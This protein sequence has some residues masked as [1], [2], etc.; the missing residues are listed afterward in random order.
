MNGSYAKG[1]VSGRSDSI[2]GHRG[3][4]TDSISSSYATGKVTGASYVGGL[5]KVRTATGRGGGSHATGGV[6]EG[7]RGRQVGGLTGANY[8]ARRQR[9]TRNA[10]A[11]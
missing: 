4:R 7:K 6:G 5:L 9:S 11:T 3:T 1:D 10:E 2:G 8:G